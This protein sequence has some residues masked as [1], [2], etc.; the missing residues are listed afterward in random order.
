VSAMTSESDDE[1]VRGVA[2][3]VAE[4]DTRAASLKELARRSLA[5]EASQELNEA[6][7]S[8]RAFATA[9]EAHEPL[10]EATQEQIVARLLRELG[11]EPEA[12]Q[13]PPPVTSISAGTPHARR[14]RRDPNLAIIEAKLQ[15]V[16]PRRNKQGKWLAAAAVAASLGVT[17][18]WLAP[19]T[20]D[21]PPAT[22]PLIV[23]A[24]QRS[25]PDGSKVV[26]SEDAQADV[27]TTAN[28][29]EVRVRLAHGSIDCDVVPNPARQFVV[30]AGAVEVVVK[31]TRFTVS[32][33]GSDGP[34]TVSV[35]RGR[36]DVRQAPGR[37]IAQLAAGEIWT[38]DGRGT[39]APPPDGGVSATSN[40][41]C[42]TCTNTASPSTAAATTR[43]PPIRRPSSMPKD[44]QSLFERA[45]AERLA[46]HSR[47][48]AVAFDE[49]RRRFPKDALAGYAA[50]M[51]GRIRLDS[52]GD[53]NGAV[54]AFTFALGTARDGFYLEDA[55]VRLVEALGKA[56]RSEECRRERDRF[57][58]EHTGSVRAQSVVDLCGA[59]E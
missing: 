59:S 36:V 15:P 23:G 46:G 42:S 54:E 30:T 18:V 51:L 34:V 9:V 1:L 45:N 12:Q 24:R 17:A 33:A 22:A 5:A 49:L 53:P 47:E 16:Q 37:V 50:F 28:P 39:R 41:M 4:Q 32:V 19:L 56:G 35:A 14:F 27:E 40:A 25:F 10:S 26:M 31:G 48:A 3:A 52:L 58:E 11:A 2:Q 8:N 43:S 44:A 55:R 13:S 6:A 20:H 57:L 38:G 7:L 29:D 21:A